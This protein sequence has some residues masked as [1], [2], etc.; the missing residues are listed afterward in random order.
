MAAERVNAVTKALAT[1]KLSHEEKGCQHGPGYASPMD[2]FLNGPREKIMYLTCV[3][4]NQ[5]GKS[6]GKPDFLATV[7]LDPD[8]PTYSKVIHRLP[9]K[10]VGDEIHHFGWNACSSCYDDASK[11][12]RF[13]VLPCL[14]TDRV[15]ILDTAQNPRAPRIHHI[16]EPE[17]VHAKTGKGMLHTSHC[18][19]SG[20]V[21]ISSIGDQHRNPKGG[22]VLLDGEDFSVIGNWEK[23]GIAA[24]MGY[25]YW[26]Q[27]AHN[28][29]VSTEWGAPHKIFKGFSP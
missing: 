18:L 23:D 12:R 7:D 9:M 16:V 28:V 6:R 29:M 26:Y 4:N 17:E 8:S 24:P 20:Q 22:F 14:D 27:P 25:D 1:A 5:E 11:C 21:M 3:R 10:Y 13:L 2:A 15:Y 19:G